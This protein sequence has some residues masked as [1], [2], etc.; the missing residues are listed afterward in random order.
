LGWEPS[1]QLD[2]GLISTITYFSELLDLPASCMPPPTKEVAS[3]AQQ[4]AQG[5]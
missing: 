4:A 3:Q 1:V 2:Q 5:L